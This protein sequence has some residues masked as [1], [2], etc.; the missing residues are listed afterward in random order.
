MPAEEVKSLTFWIRSTMPTGSVNKNQT[1]FTV[2]EQLDLIT[3]SISNAGLVRV[4]TSPDDP[5][6]SAPITQS[7]TSAF[8]PLLLERRS[9]GG[10]RYI[11]MGS[12]V[13]GFSQPTADF[14][15]SWPTKSSVTL[16]N[17]R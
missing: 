4:P 7:K 5:N 6:A 10:G 8:L 2:P 13:T 9:D 3:P 15:W 16:S 11:L 1:C 17:V 14:D 12:S